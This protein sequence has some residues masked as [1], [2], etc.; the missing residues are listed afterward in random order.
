IREV[1]SDIGAVASFK[2]ALL[3]KRLPKTRSGKVLR[4]TLRDLADGRDYAVPSTIDDPANLEE[5]EDV[6]QEFPR[7]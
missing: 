3:V 1:R 5:I 7:S 4:R 2:K 6:L